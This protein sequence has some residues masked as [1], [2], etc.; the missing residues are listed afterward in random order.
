MLLNPH[1]IALYDVWPENGTNA[2]T[3]ILSPQMITTVICDATI[4]LAA[5]QIL[6]HISNWLHNNVINNFVFVI[7]LSVC[8]QATGYVSKHIWYLS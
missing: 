4:T 8:N 2:V 1:L 5:K 3:V 7:C 6:E